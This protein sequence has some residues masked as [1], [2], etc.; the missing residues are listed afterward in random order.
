[1]GYKS[2]VVI[3]HD[4]LD[5][6]RTD[7]EEFVRRLQAACYDQNSSRGV[8]I[9]G[10][11]LANVVWSGHSRMTPVL[12]IDGYQAEE[13]QGDELRAYEAHRTARLVRERKEK[14]KDDKWDIIDENGVRMFSTSEESLAAKY[15]RKGCT[16]RLK[17]ID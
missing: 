7:A 1:M 15:E 10:A 2:V 17:K 5:L 11:P 13:V 6:A 14:E 12:R 4:F 9:D 8:S 3:D 16:R